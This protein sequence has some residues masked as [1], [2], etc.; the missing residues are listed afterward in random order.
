MVLIHDAD[1]GVEGPYSRPSN[2]TGGSLLCAAGGDPAVLLSPARRRM[3]SWVSWRSF[4]L[5]TS[6]VRGRGW[7]SR[8]SLATVSDWGAEGSSSKA[9][10]A[11]ENWPFSS[12]VVAPFVVGHRSRHRAVWRKVTRFRKSFLCGKGSLFLPGGTSSTFQP[13]RTHSSHVVERACAVPFAPA[14]LLEVTPVRAA[15]PLQLP[16][17]CES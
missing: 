6:S 17:G 1:H 10:Q 14:S 13:L 2:P 3:A 9:E 16:S 15:S 11:V 5:A 7:Q 12:R 8:I 4:L